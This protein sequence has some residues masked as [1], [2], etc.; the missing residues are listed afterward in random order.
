MPFLNWYFIM[1]DFD[2]VVFL[3]FLIPILLFI[4]Y[5]DFPWIFT[6]MISKGKAR[7]NKTEEKLNDEGGITK[8]D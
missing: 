3:I 1:F 8:K 5:F 4:I 2:S 7:R 6:W